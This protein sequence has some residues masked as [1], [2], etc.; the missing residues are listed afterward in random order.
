[1][2]GSVHRENVYSGVSL[3][4]VAKDGANVQRGRKSIGDQ[5]GFENVLGLED[6]VEKVIKTT[7]D[8]I[9]APKVLGGRYDIVLDPEL[10]GVFAHE[11]FGHLSEADFI[12][13]N[14]QARDM[15]KLGRRFGPDFLN[16]IDDGGHDR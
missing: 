6:E 4:A 10:A 9:R 2:A 16:I 15:M 1:M 13:E 3:S 8:L 12:Y 5:R 11:A 14:P 7:R